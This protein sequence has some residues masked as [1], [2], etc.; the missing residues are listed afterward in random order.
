M[1]KG[2]RPPPFKLG[3]R[4]N[5]RPLY[6]GDS[7]THVHQLT[8]IVYDTVM[9]RFTARGAYLLF[10]SLR[11]GAYRICS[12][13]H[14]GHPILQ[15]VEEA[16]YCSIHAVSFLFRRFSPKCMLVYHYGPN[17]WSNY[18]RFVELAPDFANEA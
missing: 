9:I 18:K 12:S 3:I 14:L 6:T 13:Q 5:H 2:N 10:V 15:A 1:T 11:E 8:C 7:T 4:S 16:S 17:C